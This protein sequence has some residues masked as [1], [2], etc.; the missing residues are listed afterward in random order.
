MFWLGSSSMSSNVDSTGATS[1]WDG[2]N[3][4]ASVALVVR[5]FITAPIE[6]S[7]ASDSSEDSACVP[8]DCW[9][10]S[11]C[12]STRSA[13]STSSIDRFWPSNE[14]GGG[15]TLVYVFSP[16]WDAIVL[17]VVFNGLCLCIGA[18]V[19][20]FPSTRRAGE[21]MKDISMARVDGHSCKLRVRLHGF[22]YVTC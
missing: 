10:L 5:L 22:I 19:V 20:L 9:E 17:F 8:V 3:D 13:S 14:A 12:D 6:S 18:F 11:S 15:L 16:C 1:G 7:S 21:S 2:P 4:M